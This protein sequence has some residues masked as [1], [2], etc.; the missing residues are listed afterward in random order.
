MAKYYTFFHTFLRWNL[1]L[2][3]EMEDNVAIIM[4][5]Y[6]H[7]HACVCVYF[8]SIFSFLTDFFQLI[9]YHGKYNRHTLEHSYGKE[10]QI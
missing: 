5:L 10:L 8:H 9:L 1:Q 4:Y 3:Y 7:V 6:E 2:V